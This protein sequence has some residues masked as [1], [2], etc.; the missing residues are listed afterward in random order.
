[1]KMID[2]SIL[3]TNQKELK[4]Y[5]VSNNERLSSVIGYDLEYYIRNQAIEDEKAVKQKNIIVKSAVDN[6]IMGFY[7]LKFN[8]DLYFPTSAFENVKAFELL[9]FSKNANNS[10]LLLADKTNF[11]E[12]AF[13]QLIMPKLILAAKISSAKLVYVNTPIICPLVQVFLDLGFEIP[14][15]DEI[16]KRIMYENHFNPNT[17]FMYK[18]L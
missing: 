12:Y 15:D 4:A 16:R 17:A 8:P 2:E 10:T 1:M 6:C 13:G 11:S 5:S 7:S 3:V 9:N 14:D 18:I